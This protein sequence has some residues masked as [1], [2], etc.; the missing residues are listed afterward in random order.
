MINLV[1]SD[2]DENLRGSRQVPLPEDREPPYPYKLER[3]SDLPISSGSSNGQ[4]QVRTRTCRFQMIHRNVHL[5][6]DTISGT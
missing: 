3:R 5:L 6:I 4:V 1:S 2:E